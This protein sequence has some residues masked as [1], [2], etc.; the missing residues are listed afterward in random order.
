MYYK[1]LLRVARGLSCLAIVLAALYTLI[2]V[3]AA[4]NG[5]FSHPIRGS[6]DSNIPLPAFF[7]IAG[8]VAAIFGSI[9]ARALSDENET[10][11]PVVWTLPFSRLQYAAAI[12]AVD[13]AGI[14]A[15]F[16]L[17]VGACVAFVATFGAIRYLEIP[18]DTGIQLLHFI[19]LPLGFYGMFVALT[20]S[21]FRA[22][23]GLIGWGWVGS[24]LLIILAASPLPAPW[25]M[26]LAAL[27]LINPLRYADYSHKSGHDSVNVG[28][29]PDVTH[30][31]ALTAGTECVA[32]AILCAAG[33]IAGL[34]QWRRLEA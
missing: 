31:V 13:V 23:R 33:L 12:I 28:A 17:T 10:H 5:A 6:H 15:A 2:V 11:L 14:L 27:N 1:E 25:P 7:G 21:A 26:I 4:A 29:P 24:F 34:W 16:A 9:Y 8:F 22:G 19:L 30:L 20:A 3:I 32:L 18:P